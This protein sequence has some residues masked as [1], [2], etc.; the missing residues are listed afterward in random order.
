MAIDPS[1]TDALNQLKKQLNELAGRDIGLSDERVAHV[2]FPIA[3]SSVDDAGEVTYERLFLP[4]KFC[5]QMELLDVAGNSST[6]DDGKRVF[7]LSDFLCSTDNSFAA[8]VNLVATPRSASPCYATSSLT[9]V[10]KPAQPNVFNDVRITIF[11]WAP[12]GSPAPS[13]SVD[14]RC[15]LV[16]FDIIL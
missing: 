8:P 15:R 3:S 16:Q 13:V 12:D 11:T 4:G 14:W 2:I 5:S 1:K 6:G 10:Q 9:L 7:L